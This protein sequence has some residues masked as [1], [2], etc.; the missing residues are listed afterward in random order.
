MHA[1]SLQD[2]Y[3]NF[4]LIQQTLRVTP[5]MEVGAADHVRTPDGIAALAPVST[6]IPSA[7]GKREFSVRATI[8]TNR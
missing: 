1:I 3:Y 8:Q 4:G 5:A 7:H 2:M 6:S